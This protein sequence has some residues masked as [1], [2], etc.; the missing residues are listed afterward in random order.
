MHLLFPEQKPGV[1]LE[2]K[3]NRTVATVPSSCS[4]QEELR[5]DGRGALEQWRD[6]WC[7][8]HGQ[9]NEE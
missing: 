8:R 5:E 7:V 4:E 2:D 6:G 3:E 9:G 1:L